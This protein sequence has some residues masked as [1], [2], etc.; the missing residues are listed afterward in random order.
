MSQETVEQVLGRLITDERFRRQAADS[1]EEACLQEGYRLLT[2]E[3]KLLSGLDVEL[4]AGLTGRL[5]RGLR[6]AD[7]GT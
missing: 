4:I 3:L 1:L 6:R 5:N 7:D 2:G